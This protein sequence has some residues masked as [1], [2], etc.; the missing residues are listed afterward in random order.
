[1]KPVWDWIKDSWIGK[2]ILSLWEMFFNDKRGISMRK[3][4]AFYCI[5]IGGQITVDHTTPENIHLVL[6]EII[7]GGLTLLGIVTYANMKQQ[8]L[9][10]KEYE[11]K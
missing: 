3:F 11:S 7:I 1:M 4:L 9:E 6:P 5:Y 10:P 2:Q 8:K